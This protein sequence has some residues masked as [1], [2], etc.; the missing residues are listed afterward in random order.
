MKPFLISVIAQANAIRGAN[1]NFSGVSGGGLVGR[2]MICELLVENRPQRIELGR[3]KVF[4]V[5]F[6]KLTYSLKY[7]ENI[8][9]ALLI[10]L[11]S[12][13]NYGATTFLS[14]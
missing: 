8:S 6:Y 2:G 1:G 3:T 12:I 13:K 9:Q 14:S 4:G 7:G 11:K 5:Y 10:S